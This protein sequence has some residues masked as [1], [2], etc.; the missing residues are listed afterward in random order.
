MKL[1]CGCRWSTKVA[2]KEHSTELRSEFLCWKS[3]KMR[4]ILPP[5]LSSSTLSRSFLTL[6]SP[7]N[8]HTMLFNAV[9]AVALGGGL[10]STVARSF[11]PPPRDSTESYV[12]RSQTD[13][14]LEPYIPFSLSLCFRNR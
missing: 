13:S 1:R 5:P 6:T 2:S 11:S 12:V 14:L 8:L 10:F 7:T 9:I 3:Y 4:A